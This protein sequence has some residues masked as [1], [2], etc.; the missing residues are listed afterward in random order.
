MKV[1]IVLFACSL[2]L[3]SSAQV[4]K[5]VDKHGRVHYGDQ[6]VGDFK[7]HDFKDKINSYRSV[8]YQNSDIYHDDKVVIYTKPTCPYCIKA[9]SFFKKNKI[10][11]KEYDITNSNYAMRKYERLKATGVPVT[12]IGKN[13]INGF[14][15]ARFEREFADF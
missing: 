3:V 5:W 12:F 11:Y 1:L 13:R 4:Y 14:S 8:T 9:L 2:S 10:K 6:Q 15:L 7:P